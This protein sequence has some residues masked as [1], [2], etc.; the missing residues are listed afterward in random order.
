MVLLQMLL[1]TE[2]DL[3]TMKEPMAIPVFGRG[4]A[5]YALVGK[6]INEE[7]IEVSLQVRDRPVRF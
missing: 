1:N 6:G 5:L 3:K 2:D 7:T 4:R